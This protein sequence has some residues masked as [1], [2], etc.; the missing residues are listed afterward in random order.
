MNDELRVLPGNHTPID[1]LI[2]QLLHIRSDVV[3]SLWKKLRKNH[4]NVIIERRKSAAK[5]KL[6]RSHS[7]EAK[8]KPVEP[9]S[10]RLS[11]FHFHFPSTPQPIVSKHNRRSILFYLGVSSALGKT[12]SRENRINSGASRALF[13]SRTE[14]VIVKRPQKHSKKFTQSCSRVEELINS[15]N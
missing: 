3:A 1:Q 6:L 15:S 2:I 5:F 13:N 10:L 8:Q 9:F 7:G 14:S 12:T 4:Q 11:L